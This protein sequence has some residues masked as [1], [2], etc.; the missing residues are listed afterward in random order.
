VDFTIPV[1]F[2]SVMLDRII[3]ADMARELLIEIGTEE[4]PASMVITGAEQLLGN[5]L[6]ILDESHISHGNG[7]WLATP[8]RL[9]VVVYE[10]AENQD[11][12]EKQVVGPPAKVAFDSDGNPTK[13]ALGFARSVGVDVSELKVV[14]T[15]KGRYVAA[16]VRE[17]GAPTIEILKET[18]PNAISEIKFPKSMRWVNSFRFA[19]PIRWLVALFGNEVIEFE[20][21][22][23]RSGRKT[24]GHRLIANI[25]IE[26]PEASAYEEVL[27]KHFVIPN[28]EERRNLVEKLAEE[29]AAK[30]G[31][32]IVKD[33]NYP[34]LL[35]EVTNLV[36]YPTAVLGSFD[37]KYLELPRCVVV[38]AMRQHQRYFSVEDAN[39][40]LMNYFV[41]IAN[42]LPDYVELMRPGL[43]KVLK[44]RLEDAKFYYDVDLKRK[45]EERLEDLKG[46]VWREGLGS[47]YDKVLRVKELALKLAHEDPD[48]DLKALER[49]ALLAKTD[50][51]TEMIRDGKEFT[52]LE[53]EIGMEYALRQGESEKVAR[54]IFEHHL[55]RF[56]GDRLPQLR[57]AAWLALADRLDT[58]VGILS[59]GYEVTGSQDPLGLRRIAYGLIDI[60]LGL[61]LRVP[62]D[63]AIR[64]AAEPFGNSELTSKT[65]EFILSRFEN[66]LEEREGVR[67]D[68]VDAV[69][70]SGATDLVNL[71]KRALA[72]KKLMESEP[73]VF[74]DVVIGQKRVAN[75]LQKF[76]PKQLPDTSLFEKPEEHT[77]FERAREV[78]PRVEAAVNSEDFEG[79]LRALLELREP[80]DRFF[81]NVF[82][83][84]DDERIRNNRLS[85]L[86]FVRSIFKL[87]GDFSK[88]AM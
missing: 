2:N 86:A 28:F 60:V 42:N 22:E 40:R 78:K 77:L 57:E 81:D 83:M 23:L 71:R 80:I 73:Q 39:G 17:G 26:I 45:L 61:N 13:A 68:V 55:P 59:T 33:E 52:K 79:A 49:G 85:L 12:I 48:V 15:E 82:V 1:S 37:E 70:A 34:E 14:E 47:V 3:C 44:A 11:V 72:L 75:I 56:A 84:T 62:M 35:D 41:A 9:A 6:K 4:L 16:T 8:R 32:R 54:I 50:L 63:E 74:E 66:Y 53:G 88:I 38:T 10:V 67:Y 64:M 69:I 76:E 5:I 30:V 19:R 58:M 21:V 18:I 65:L 27:K 20:L 29:A 87:Y 31:G 36:E 51:T 46:I 7:R 25:E 43:E 24:R